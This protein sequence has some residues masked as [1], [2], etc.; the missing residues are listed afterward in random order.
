MTTDMKTQQVLQPMQTL[1]N[2]MQIHAFAKVNLFLHVV[3]K[4]PDG[5]H[6][7]D[8]L[9]VFAGIG[10][11]LS[12]SA[13]PM[14]NLKVE[15]PFA[16][17][18]QHESNN[19]VLRAV[20]A[21]QKHLLPGRLM[22]GAKI[23]LTKRLPVSSGIGGGS[24]DAA[25]AMKLCA[26]LWQIHLSP[27]EW[28]QLGLRL[29]A[30]VPVCLMG[31]PRRMQGIGELLFPVPQLPNFWLVLVNPLLAVPTAAVFKQ[32]QGAVFSKPAPAFPVGGWKTVED[33]AS[34]LNNCQND[35]T[36]PAQQL[37][38]AIKIVLQTLKL[39]KDQLLVRMS[40]SGATCWA[41]F[42]HEHQARQAAQLLSQQHPDWWV[43]AAPVLKKEQ[44]LEILGNAYN[45]GHVVT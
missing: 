10:D 31:E 14:L 9:V 13:N 17:Q 43:A 15:G 23:T 24:A 30:D 40:G 39:L 19:I 37:Q 34:Y 44:P 42:A 12:L 35:L 33:L 27:P 1:E 11:T 8:S 29:G 3:G 21:L 25:A 6:V 16:H 22:R 7:L 4:R 26:H 36:E 20:E 38:P 28:L 2:P 18:L 32:R 45:N 41:M 5:Y